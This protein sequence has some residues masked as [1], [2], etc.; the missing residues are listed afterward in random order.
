MPFVKPFLS[1]IFAGIVFVAPAQEAQHYFELGSKH[2]AEYKFDSAIFYFERSKAASPGSLIE[3][4]SCQSLGDI[5]KYDL[6][7]FDEAEKNYQ[8]ALELWSRLD[9]SDT[10]GLTRL[11]YN[12]ATTNRSQHDYETSI[13]WCLKAVEG[14]IAMKDNAFLERSYSILGNIYRDMHRYDSAVVYYQKGV[15]VNNQINKGKQNET[16]AGLY[17]GWGEAS[18]MQGD[19]DDAAKRLSMSVAIYQSLESPDKSI[20]MHTVMLFAKVCIERYDLDQASFLLSVAEHL[21]TTLNLE[22]GGPVALLYGTFGDYMARTGNHNSAYKYYQRSLQATTLEQLDE[23]SNPTEIDRVDFKGFAYDALLSKADALI[24]TNH[25]DEA[26]DC[27]SIAEKLMIAGRKELDTEDARWNY[28]DASFRLYENALSALHRLNDP[29]HADLTLHFMEASKSKSLADALQEV[30]LRKVLGPNDTLLSRLR[31]LRQHSLKLQHQINEKDESSVRDQLIRTGQQISAVEAS[32]NSVY[33]SYLKTRYENITTQL[34]ELKEKIRKSSAVLVEYFWG[35]DNIYAIVVSDGIEL[36]HLGKPAEVQPSISKLVDHLTAKTNR[37][38]PADV[39]DFAN[40]SNAL[41]RTLLQPFEDKLAGKKR[42]VVVP[43]GPLIQI[44]FE[45]L[46]TQFEPG[47]AYNKLKY[48]LSTHIVSYGFSGSYFASERKPAKRSPSLLAFG[49]T[50]MSDVPSPDP[51]I[52]DI[53]GSETELIAL[54][55][56][57]PNGTYLY[58]PDVTER[59]FKSDA[60]KYD[61]IHLAVHG[62]SD[63]NRDYAATFY[64]RDASGPEDGRLYWY[65]LYSMNLRASLAVLSSCESGIGKTYKGE[66]MLSMANA[67]TFAGCSNVVMG[68]WKVDDQVSVKL[69]DTFYSELLD[70]MAI[71]EAL[72]LAKRAYLASADQVT[73]NPKLWGSLVAYG[74]AQVVRP[75]E[76]H[77]GWFILALT[78]LLAGIFFLVRKT[79]K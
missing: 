48:L 53:A 19:L 46:V 30:E 42:V 29:S 15:A 63:T 32:L 9:P 55:Q 62:S 34:P 70:G 58:G 4:R 65:E 31:A 24:A 16:L 68:L 1:L 56:K 51:N 50:G 3:A 36:F 49:F 39:G 13:T 26:L 77:T 22:R 35:F 67:F 69:M 33:P 78:V 21:K 12:L 2:L 6:Y 74:E 14:S 28:I 75:D 47:T 57:F 40:V 18:Y 76:I 41:Y 45:T 23:N 37:Y 27:F 54:S 64:F 61:L 10:R 79:K 66:G 72:A 59:R 60:G 44:P 5:F 17:S 8:R 73:A 43:D 20:Y 38:S 11:Y 25:V 7:N 71:D 52:T